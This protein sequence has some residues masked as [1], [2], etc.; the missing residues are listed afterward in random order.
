MGGYD[1]GLL[2][3]RAAVGLA[4]GERIAI[5]RPGYLG[6]PLA[7]G[8]SP[9]QQA[10][11]CA[12]LLDALAIRRA[13][14]VAISG[15]GQCA[16]QFALRHA[17]RCRA[18]VM[19]SASSAPLTERVPWRFHVMAFM[20][21]F[22]GVVSRMKRR[23]EADPERAAGRFIPDPVLRAQTLNDPEAGP[24]VRAHLASTLERMAE[25]LPGTRNDILQSRAAFTYPVERI[26]AP[27]LSIHGT[28][29][30]AVPFAQAKSLTDRLPHGELLPIPEGQHACL[31]THRRLIQPRVRAFL[32]LDEAA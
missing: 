11:L 10:D 21:R 16:L 32:E 15:G 13:A 14:V 27:V 17:D 31:F 25:R 30:Q 26:V 2:L 24:M 7:R 23:A 5:S 9:E 3:G 29:D 28:A 18:L 22:P 1:Q 20:A 6:T 4:G 8:S 19:I 12:A